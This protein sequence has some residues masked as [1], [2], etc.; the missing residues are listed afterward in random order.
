MKGNVMQRGA[1]VVSGHTPGPWRK[2]KWGGS[3]VANHRA[4]RVAGSD[5]VEFYGGHL[6]AESIAPQNIPLIAAAPR[7]SDALWSL[8]VAVGQLSLTPEQ[9]AI[10]AAACDEASAALIESGRVLG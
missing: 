8:L 4:P 9:R 5:E 3:V 10:V 2:G 6:I 1:A 7:M